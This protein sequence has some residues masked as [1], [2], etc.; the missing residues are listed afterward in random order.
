MEYR[1]SDL[2]S[3]KQVYS[4]VGTAPLHNSHRTVI[5]TLFHGQQAVSFGTGASADVKLWNRCGLTFN[6]SNTV[7]TVY[8]KETPT[9][10]NRT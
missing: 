1:V 2:L 7:R 6:V 5:T 10:F 3:K 9:S 4:S 8:Q